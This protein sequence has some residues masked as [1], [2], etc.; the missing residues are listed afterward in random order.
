MTSPFDA[1]NE[2]S[3][4]RLESFVRGLSDEQ[5]RRPAPYG[6]TVSGLIA[7][8]AVF[9]R[10]VTVL[11][12]RWRADGMDDAPVDSAMIN[13]ALAPILAALEPRTAVELCLRA[14]AECDAEVAQVTPEF[15]AAIEASGNFMRLDR[16]LHRAAHLADIEQFLGSKQ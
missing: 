8:L 15:Q 5:L 6:E 1:A 4:A 16:S 13:D 3:R 7:H 9:D 12:R 10:R 2:A 14:A 11:L